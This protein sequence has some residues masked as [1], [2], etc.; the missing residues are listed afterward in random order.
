MSL[1]KLKL[2]PYNNFSVNLRDPTINDI[3][4][5]NLALL[6]GNNNF[7]SG[8][9]CTQTFN[10]GLEVASLTVGGNLGVSSGSVF[11]VDVPDLGS[12]R[13]SLSQDQTLNGNYHLTTLNVP[14]VGGFSGE[15]KYEYE[16]R[17]QSLYGMCGKLL[18]S[19]ILDTQTFTE[20]GNAGKKFK[21]GFTQH[22][23]T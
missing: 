8:S 19:T 22:I 7:C 23:F 21:K 17:D 6:N 11:G 9:S 12:T 10:G 2:Y 16:G 13:V 4:P 18:L 20:V 14:S 5:D 1:K 3:S 15:I